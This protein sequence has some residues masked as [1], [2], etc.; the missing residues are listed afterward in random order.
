MYHADPSRGYQPFFII[1]DSLLPDLCM[2][3][4]LIMYVN[5]SCTSQFE[6]HQV[7]RTESIYNLSCDP[8]LTLWMR[9]N[10][11][12]LWAELSLWSRTYMYT[13]LASNS[14]WCIHSSWHLWH[15]LWYYEQ[16]VI[17]MLGSGI[18]LQQIT[19]PWCMM[20]ELSICYPSKL[21]TSP[22]SLG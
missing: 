11:L 22:H 12:I 19:H 16:Y 21:I 8:D 18:L 1:I 7:G 15:L 9:H 13:A 17:M 6:P 3:N 10:A 5:R 2:S 20:Y 14:P 4:C